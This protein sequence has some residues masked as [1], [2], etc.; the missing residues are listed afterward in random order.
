MINIANITALNDLQE[1]LQSITPDHLTAYERKSDPVAEDDKIIG[2]IAWAETRALFA[3]RKVLTTESR[4]E[5]L[6]AESAIAEENE[7]E[8]ESRACIA[9][10][11]GDV[12]GELCWFQ[13][14]SELGYWK[15]GNIGIRKGWT[16]VQLSED[17]DSPL[18]TILARARLPRK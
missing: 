7:I 3:L 2:T 6:K 12:I 13:A 17:D 16:L 15:R 11:L 9:S 10:E 1:R 8:F 18:A 14:R 5:L 4:A